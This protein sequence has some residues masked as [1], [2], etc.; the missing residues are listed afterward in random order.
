MLLLMPLCLGVGL[1]YPPD[2]G[3]VST[4]YRRWRKVADALEFREFDSALHDGASAQLQ[5]LFVPSFLP[6][7]LIIL[8]SFHNPDHRTFARSF[9]R[10][11]QHRIIRSEISVLWTLGH[12]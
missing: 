12:A 2:G 6:D 11:N 3:A 7:T 5:L 10:A 8:E 4:K 9:A 1:F